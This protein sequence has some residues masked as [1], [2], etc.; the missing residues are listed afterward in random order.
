MKRKEMRKRGLTTW[1]L[2]IGI[3]AALLVLTV[4]VAILTFGRTR[5]DSIFAYLKKPGNFNV[6]F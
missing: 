3:L 5:L 6:P 2:V 4:V 1:Q